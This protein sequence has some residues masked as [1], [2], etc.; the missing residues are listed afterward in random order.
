[1]ERLEG[2]YRLIYPELPEG[3]TTIFRSTE[4]IDQMT[5]A[6]LGATEATLPLDTFLNEERDDNAGKNVELSTEERQ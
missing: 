4:D 1:M 3:A 6:S 2:R 5:A